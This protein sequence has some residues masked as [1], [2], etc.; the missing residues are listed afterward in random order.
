MIYRWLKEG[1]TCGEL[2]QKLGCTVNSITIGGIIVGSEIKQG[3]ELDLENETPEILQRLDLK[4]AG[5]VREGGHDVESI[6]SENIVT[7]HPNPH[8]EAFKLSPLYGM[9]QQ[10]LETYIENNITDLHAAKE[11]LKKM[12]AVVLWLVKQNKMDE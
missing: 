11:F 5:L 1:K 6:I 2:G 10:Q 9:T 7:E 4:L 8:K 3:I 12:A